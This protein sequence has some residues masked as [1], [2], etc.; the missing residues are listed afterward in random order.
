MCLRDFCE[1]VVDEECDWLQR[2]T[3]DVSESQADLT[4]ERHEVTVFK[5]EDFLLPGSLKAAELEKLKNK[6]ACGIGENVPVKKIGE[7]L[8]F[9]SYF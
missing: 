8:M 4:G 3:A 7:K 1:Y 2:H 5:D 9:R 6:D